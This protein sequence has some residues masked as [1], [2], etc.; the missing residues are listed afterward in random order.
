MNNT[1][2]L[3]KAERKQAKL[4]IGLFGPS[5]SGKTMSALKIARGITD[6]DKICVIDT[7]NGS[8]EM[9]SHLGSYNVIAV[10][11]PFN[12]ERYIEAIQAAEKA[13]ME[14]IIIDSIT[15]EWQGRGGILELSEDMEK[16]FKN[17][18]MVWGKLTPRH[19][20][21]IDSILESPCHMIC[22]GRAKQDYVINQKEKNGHTINVPEK[23]GLKAITREGFDYEMTL[24]FEIAISHYATTAK[25]RTGLFMDK[26]EF[27]ISEAIGETLKKWNEGGV[28]DVNE[29]KKEIM[30]QLRRIGIAIT[31]ATGEQIK[32]DIAELTGLSLEPDNFI[33]IIEKLK[34][35]PEI[36]D[37]KSP[38]VTPVQTSEQILGID[39]PQAPTI[40][41]EEKKQ[42]EPA[43]N[44]T[45]EAISPATDEDKALEEKNSK[46]I[47]S[48]LTGE[49]IPEKK[50]E[51][52]PEDTSGPAKKSQITLLRSLAK[53]K[54][55]I[56]DDDGIMTYIRTFFNF[57]VESVDKLTAFQS[58]QISE[59]LLS[60]K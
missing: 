30:R 47:N 4:R 48:I 43:N 6:W 11:A 55:G 15:H 44:T 29:Q 45:E 3:R 56:N 33:G 36:P 17:S 40:A 10:Q 20:K 8:G 57:E 1:F 27:I 22:C 7:E 18:F 49:P 37:G 14:V 21:F 58:K 24:S 50:E 2:T 26:P 25:D 59:M 38:E 5:G 53:Q 42:P 13:G 19:N 34:A 35:T 28:V 12:P 60:N 54:Q 23:V 46:T 32:A 51:S 52:L 39:N 31:G 9:Y 41:Q 16:G